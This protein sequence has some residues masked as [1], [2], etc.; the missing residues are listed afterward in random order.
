MQMLEEF[1]TMQEKH[2][3]QINVAKHCI[4]LERFN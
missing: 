1:K 3:V 2:L 4:K